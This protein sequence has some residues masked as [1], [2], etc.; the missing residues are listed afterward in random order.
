[1]DSAAIRAY[2]NRRWDLVEDAERRTRAEQFLKGGPAG[3]LA[4]LGELRVRF[5]RLHPEGA[6]AEERA[7][8]LR[9]LVAFA[10]KVRAVSDALARR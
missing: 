8:S 6:P 9:E 10:A 3:Q 2:R 5:S 7:R 4:R 1:M